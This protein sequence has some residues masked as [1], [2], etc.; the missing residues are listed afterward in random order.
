MII[1]DN[2]TVCGYCGGDIPQ[3]TTNQAATAPRTAP[4]KPVAADPDSEGEEDDGLSGYLQPGEQVQVAALNVSVKKFFFH[5]YLTNQRIFL[6]DTQEPKL[7]VKTKV[8]ATA[9]DI[10]LDTIVGS[11]IEF[12]EN[13]DPV[14]VLSMK[15]V[16]DEVKTMKLV[17]AQNG[18][19][20]SEEIDEWIAI[21][22]GPAEQKK[23]AKKS[24]KEPVKVP[25]AAPPRRKEYE[26]AAEVAE[27]E[28]EPEEVIEFIQPEKPVVQRQGLQPT[29]KPVKNHE[30]QPP[31]KRLVPIYKPEPEP[32]EDEEYDEPVAPPVRQRQIRQMP[33]TAKKPVITR[34]YDYAPPT[35]PSGDD[36]AHPVRKPEVQS[37]MKVAMKSAM[38]PLRQPAV[39]QIR[40]Q[41]VAE[42]VH[43][44]VY[45][46]EPEERMQPARRPAIPE[47]AEEK[48]AVEEVVEVPQFCHN[49]G[50]KLPPTAN[51]C[52]GCGT[53]LNPNRTLPRIT[54]KT[55]AP[56]PVQERKMQPAER[57][58]VRPVIV[59]DDEHEDETPQPV[60]PPI[61]KAP[62]G[63]EMTILHKFLRR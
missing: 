19:D 26:E 6:I 63:S 43:H 24:V 29:R 27:E 42:P 48:P 2:I 17:F 58:S 28:E 22:N 53:K 25:K 56:A 11:I 41:P 30:K 20:R 14:L 37:A 16:D 23:P 60:K 1:R 49:C 5:A 4:A 38:Q 15:S 45:E 13:S 46:P 36:D 12:S 9:K 50:K 55:P 34:S 44:P 8:K 59:D 47:R 61:K 10:P 21:L 39:H 52:P 57:R 54:S 51:F 31:V 3:H 40:R 32:V 35:P 18:M 7:K 62:Q 33:E